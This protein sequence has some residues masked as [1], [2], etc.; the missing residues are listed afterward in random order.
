MSHRRKGH[1]TPTV[2]QTCADSSP[3]NVSTWI[4]EAV[5][6]P[7]PGESEADSAIK[8]L[9]PDKICLYDRGDSGF[10]LLRAH[11]EDVESDDAVP[12][13]KSHFVV[14]YRKEGGN[15]P[16]SSPAMTTVSRKYFG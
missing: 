15:S 11:F 7:D 3:L 13:V 10:A 6:V 12:I 4:P 16:S 14:R 9:Q 5:V 1:H 2:A 8:N